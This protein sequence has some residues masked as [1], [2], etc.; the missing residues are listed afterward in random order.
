MRHFGGFSYLDLT[1]S[2]VSELYWGSGNE[3]KTLSG[4]VRLYSAAARECMVFR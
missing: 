3:T 1:I 4:T 2:E